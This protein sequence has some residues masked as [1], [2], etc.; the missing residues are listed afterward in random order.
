MKKFMKNTLSALVFSSATLFNSFSQ[1]S[2]DTARSR[3]TEYKSLMGCPYGT[4]CY[5]NDSANICIKPDNETGHGLVEWLNA[6][7]LDG[8]LEYNED[9]ETI[10]RRNFLITLHEKGELNSSLRD[11]IYLDCPGCEKHYNSFLD[12]KKDLTE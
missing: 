3:C 10:S 6:L 1:E 2:S 9:M 8:K 12:L 7:R 11:E 4:I 5:H